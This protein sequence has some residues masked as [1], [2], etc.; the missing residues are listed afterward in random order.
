M[1]MYNQFPNANSKYAA[2]DAMNPG[3]AINMQAN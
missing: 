2:F 3:G 1:N